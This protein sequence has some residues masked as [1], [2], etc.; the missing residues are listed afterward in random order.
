MTNNFYCEINCSIVF[1][2]INLRFFW[3]AKI[4][5]LLVRKEID[6]YG[7]IYIYTIFHAKKLFEYVRSD[8]K[9]IPTY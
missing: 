9:Y 5:E 4:A 3:E 2:K 1:Q 7:N 6:A 8:N